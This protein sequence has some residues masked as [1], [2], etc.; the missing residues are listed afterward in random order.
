[1]AEKTN[2]KT[3]VK[4]TKRGL[5]RVKSHLKR[6][7]K[8][9]LAS[10]AGVG[11]LGI[12]YAALRRKKMLRIEKPKVVKVKPKISEPIIDLKPKSKPSSS[13]RPNQ[14]LKNPNP[15]TE[16]KLGSVK[17]RFQNLL[18]ERASLGRVKKDFIDQQGKRR[19]KGQMLPGIKKN[20]VNAKYLGEPGNL[21]RRVAVDINTL[22]II[23]PEFKQGKVNLTPRN[24]DLVNEVRARRVLN[25]KKK[26]N[27]D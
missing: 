11:V 12:G 19:K 7:R 21:K 4:K 3:Y 14:G 10:A 24:R 17:S 9:I 26:N 20:D 8:K 18:P 5:R 23:D 2:V 16:T 1:M 15:N 22:D 27:K 6:N 25:L 13:P